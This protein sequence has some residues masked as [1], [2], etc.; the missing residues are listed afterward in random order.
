MC[1]VVVGESKH[2]HTNK[3]T[4]TQFKMALPLAESF[5]ESCLLEDYVVDTSTATNKSW[6][7]RV[8]FAFDCFYLSVSK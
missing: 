3:L 5:R 1:G 8:L 4:N 7:F 6:I 2:A